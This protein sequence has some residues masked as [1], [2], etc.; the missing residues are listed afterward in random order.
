MTV[1]WQFTRSSPLQE[2]Y[3]PREEEL[4]K[5]YCSYCEAL[6]RE[7]VQNAL[8]ARTGEGLRIKIGFGVRPFSGWLDGITDHI[9][10]CFRERHLKLSVDQ[11][12]YLSLRTGREGKFLTLEDFETTGLTGEIR[13]DKTPE[14]SNFY[15][16]VYWAGGSR[17]TGRKGGRW[18]VGKNVYYMCSGVRTFFALTKRHD[19]GRRLLVGKCTLGPHTLNNERFAHDGYF[20][21]ESGDPVEDPHIIEN[22]SRDFGVERNVPGLSIVIPFAQTEITPEAVKAALVSHYFYPIARGTLSAE[23]TDGR[24]HVEINSETLPQIAGQL[25]WKDT[26][27]QTKKREEV[28]KLLRFMYECQRITPITIPAPHM[29]NLTPVIEK[30][31]IRDRYFNGGILAFKV[32]VVVEPREA[33]SIQSFFTVYFQRD[34]SLKNTEAFFIRSDLL[35]PGPAENMRGRCVRMMV[36]ADDEGIAQFLGDAETPY[37]ENWTLKGTGLSQKYKNAQEILKLVKNFPIQ[38]VDTLEGLCLERKDWEL[39]KKYFHIL[40]PKSPPDKDV[41]KRRP[42]KPIRKGIRLLEV[43]P[44]GQGFRLQLTAEGKRR[45]PIRAK[46]TCAY[47]TLKGDARNYYELTDF[48]MRTISVQHRG[49]SVVRREENLLELEISD[50]NFELEA[51]GFDPNRDLRI[52]VEAFHGE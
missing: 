28:E 26:Y 5:N 6:V 41:T 40:R 19:D 12:A 47:A 22:F 37:H 23:I 45:L 8:D 34:G 9:E 39:F 46:I 14:E 43:T 10:A 38:L 50:H 3:V 31:N 36:L 20:R 51:S 13:R 21:E 1:D 42:P 30:M 18:G 17:K 44:A 4:L 48:D 52:W 32:P 7:F 49:C 2:Q 27:W 16:F 11:D 29:D 25:E 24:E 35:I 15:D 33:E